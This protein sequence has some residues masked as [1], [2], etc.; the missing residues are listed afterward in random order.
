MVLVRTANLS[1][2]STDIEVLDLSNNP[3]LGYLGFSQTNF[4]SFD[5]RNC[6]DAYFLDLKFAPVA[7]VEI[8]NNAT[9][10]F[11]ITDSTILLEVP[12]DSFDITEVLPGIDPAKITMESG[13][14]ID[15]KI[16]SG[17]SFDTPIVYTYDCGI[18]N[19]GAATLKVTA[20]LAEKIPT[21][22]ENV[23]ESDNTTG[24]DALDTDVPS[25]SD[26]T[27]PPATG[28]SGITLW[29]IMLLL[30]ASVITIN[31]TYKKNR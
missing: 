14:Q 31:M 28:D 2:A 27:T 3:L 21:A 15:D 18:S 9:L 23:P 6:Q 8:G 1:L 12:K 29:I 19:Q 17:Y 10:Q 5:I 30:S 24:G 7:W 22:D 20:N 16:V 11:E 13:A 4:T 26:S 25:S